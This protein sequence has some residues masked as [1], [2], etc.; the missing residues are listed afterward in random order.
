MTRHDRLVEFSEIRSVI[1][2][3]KGCDAEIHI[4][5]KEKNSI[6][7]KCPVCKALFS[8]ADRSAASGAISFILASQKLDGISLTLNV[9]ERSPES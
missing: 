3:C 1:A 8:N 2:R 6:G 9:P 5:I 4:P 7:E